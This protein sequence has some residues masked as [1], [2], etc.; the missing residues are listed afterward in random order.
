MLTPPL[1][2]ACIDHTNT[3]YGIAAALEGR[4]WTRVPYIYFDLLCMPRDDDFED[5]DVS[6]KDKHN[7][8]IFH[9]LIKFNSEIHI[10]GTASMR[11]GMV[12]KDL[13][14]VE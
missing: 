14:R 6:Y 10:F 13:C 1:P 8:Y 11:R 2:G 9:E 4:G 12:L 7:K 5:S 3:L